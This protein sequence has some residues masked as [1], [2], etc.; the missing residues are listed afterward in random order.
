MTAAETPKPLLP[1]DFAEATEAWLSVVRAYNNCTAAISAQIAPLG[2]TLLQHETLINLLRTPGITQ[3]QLAV[4][5][6]SA[7]SGISML[8][9]RF[10]TDGIIR[11]QSDPGDKRAYL[12]DLTETGKLLAQQ[13]LQVQLGVIKEMSGVFEP[14]EMPV[15]K[16]RMDQMSDILIA[17]ASKAD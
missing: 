13:A 2:I 17:I 8:I 16:S 12:L 3:Q 4:R 5:C 10:E 11:R 15:L 6:F 1:A 7:K 9:A 14:E